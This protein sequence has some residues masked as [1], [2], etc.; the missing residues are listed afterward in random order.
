MVEYTLELVLPKGNTFRN[1]YRQLT[2]ARLG[3]VNLIKHYGKDNTFVNII[4]I[5]KGARPIVE[6]IDFDEYIQDWTCLQ[7]S[8]AVKGKKSRKY[9]LS[10]KTG[11]LLDWD[12]NWRYL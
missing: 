8:D 10:P 4:K 12:K 1:G 2:S 3:A 5:I 9:R 11:K 7:Y 6:R